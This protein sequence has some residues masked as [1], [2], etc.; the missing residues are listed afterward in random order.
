MLIRAILHVLGFQPFGSQDLLVE[1]PI[2]NPLPE[3]EHRVMLIIEKLYANIALG[4][5]P[6]GIQALSSG[7]WL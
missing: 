6:Y 2:L 7:N 5:Q 3:T 1:P 4:G